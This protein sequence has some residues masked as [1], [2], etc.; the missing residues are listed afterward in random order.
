MHAR[1]VLAQKLLGN[2]SARV[3]QFLQGNTDPPK[4]SSYAVACQ[5]SLQ[6]TPDG[7][8]YQLRPCPGCPVITG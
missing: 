4:F 8:G 6:V 5:Y 7:L 2:E 1:P 3:G